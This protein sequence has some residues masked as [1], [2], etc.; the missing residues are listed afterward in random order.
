MLEP[1]GQVPVAVQ[2]IGTVYY[3][4]KDVFVTDRLLVRAGRKVGLAQL[5]NVHTR[6]AALS[7]TTVNAAI[8]VGA[9]GLLLVAAGS[10]LDTT[11][12]LVTSAVL[13]VPLAVV[14]AG[15][16]RR[17]PY[18]LWADCASQGPDGAVA[19][20]RLLRVS[21]PERYRQICRAIVRAQERG[22][23]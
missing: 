20:I 16:L 7:P 21:D 17:R 22:R 9:A 19:R 8:A 13:A 6:R 4:H 2:P 23:S 10:L 5:S 14:L 18:E 15:L 1:T 11:A 12:W 3:R